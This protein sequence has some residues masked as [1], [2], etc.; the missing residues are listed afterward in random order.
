MAKKKAP[1]TPAAPGDPGD[2]P[3]Q[4]PAVD[5]A[6]GTPAD[7]YRAVAIRYFRYAGEN[8]IY[9]MEARNNSWLR[10]DVTDP[11]EVPL[12]QGAFASKAFTV[13]IFYYLGDTR[14]YVRNVAVMSP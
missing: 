5:R 7:D 12:I 10:Y 8:I 11:S 9:F 1:K 13:I 4:R 2:P 14:Y 3:P 6:A